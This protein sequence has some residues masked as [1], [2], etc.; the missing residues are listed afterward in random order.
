MIELGA[1]ALS[2]PDGPLC[3]R[4]RCSVPHLHRQTGQPSSRHDDETAPREMKTHPNPAL[5]S[6]ANRPQSR[7]APAI[8]TAAVSWR[9]K[10]VH[11]RRFRRPCLHHKQHASAPV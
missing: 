4:L 5:P 6:A 1:V 8:W 3:P 2:T 7:S 9:T 11:V 10:P